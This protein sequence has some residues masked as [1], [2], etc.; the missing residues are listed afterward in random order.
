M[1]R[2]Y[3]KII[4][5]FALITIITLASSNMAYKFVSASSSSSSLTV[6][7]QYIKDVSGNTVVL[8][9]VDYTGFVD[10][11]LGSWTMPNGNIEWNTWNTAAIGNNLDAMESWGANCV[12]VYMTVQFWV[13][14]TDNFQ[15][16]IAYFI[17]QCQQRSMYVE[18]TYWRNNVAEPQVTM[19]YTDPGNGYINSP[20]DFVNL[21]ASTANV[22][23]A[24]PNVI[25]Q[26]WNEPVGDGSH[27]TE[28]TWFNTAQQ[29]ITAI[30]GTGATNLI[31]VQ[32]GNCLAWSAAGFRSDL[33]WVTQYPLYDPLG[34]IVY[35]EHIYRNNFFDEYKNRAELYSL[36][37]M[38]QALTDDGVFS[39]GKPL[40][41]SEIA[42][43]STQA[44]LDNGL[45][46]TWFANTLSLLN[47]NGIGYLVFDWDPY[48]T[49]CSAYGLNT[50]G[51]T[52]YAP[53]QSGQ[54]L[55]QA[56]SYNAITSSGSGQGA[57]GNSNIGAFSNS[58]PTGVKQGVL[59]QL[60]DNNAV[61]N[62]IVWYGHVDN[63]AEMKCAIYSNVNGVPNT[64]LAQTQAVTVGTSDSWVTFPIGSPVTLQS[65]SYWLSFI[66]E[67]PPASNVYFYYDAGT[68]SQRARSATYPFAQEFTATFEN[69]FIY[70]SEAVS[71]YATYTTSSTNQG[72]FGNSN[73]GA[74]SNSG[75]TGVKQG[76]LYQLKDNNAV[77]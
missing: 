63:T 40:L 39:L 31:G 15:S 16:N 23:K 7:G 60:K 69:V 42:A 10:G 30:R 55:Q 52:N 56:L 43:D 14:N 21:W 32:W 18:L 34:N 1:Q 70:D 3:G 48:D 54:I 71:I 61:V 62:S 6:D 2:N 33:S 46:Y 75:P 37:D 12:N 36:S 27:T 11:P 49:Y 5:I 38:T 8:R 66:E 51:Q 77:V 26:L 65:G 57:F 47:Q 24:Y 29:C 58:G 76:V 45:E 4:L 67:R 25:F 20:T 17:G 50:H 72:A 19:P 35:N 68:A 13:K 74:F 44:S 41:I 9:G 64:L 59:Y 22:L 73:I 28:A 53:S